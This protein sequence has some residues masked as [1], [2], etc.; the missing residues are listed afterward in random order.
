M[1]CEPDTIKKLSTLAP[2]FIVNPLSGEIIASTEPDFN[3][4]ISPTAPASIFVIPL[5]SPVIIP[6]TVKD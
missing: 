3:L 1:V 2:V 5:P 6:P 4:S